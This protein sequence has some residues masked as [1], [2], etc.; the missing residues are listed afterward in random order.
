MRA[1][2]KNGTIIN[3]LILRH[4]WFLHVVVLGK[5]E[6]HYTIGLFKKGV[7]PF[8]DFALILVE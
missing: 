2:V 4:M 3:M 5:V 7:Q 8:S 6:P 1:Y